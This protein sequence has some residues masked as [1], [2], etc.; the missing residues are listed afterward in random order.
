V[1]LKDMNNLLYQV[2]K[3][4]L[5]LSS[6]LANIIFSNIIIGIGT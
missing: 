3:L 6:L 5:Q 1:P 2:K 4:I